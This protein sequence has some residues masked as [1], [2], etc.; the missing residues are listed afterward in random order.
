MRDKRPVESPKLGPEDLDPAPEFLND[1]AKREWKRILTDLVDTGLVCSVDQ[2]ALAAYCQTY[3]RWMEAER[4]VHASGLLVKVNGV[5]VPNPYL[6][7]ADRSMA[8]MRLFLREFG[9]SPSSRVRIQ[10]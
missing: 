5:P 8:Q 9:L 2:A 3:S 1:E 6:S 10:R 7:I 4:Q